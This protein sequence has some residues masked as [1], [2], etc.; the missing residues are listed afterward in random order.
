[1]AGQTD[2][3]VTQLRYFVKAAKLGSMSKA[4]RSLFV[5]EQALSKGVHC[6]EEALGAELLARS[7]T[8]V[9]TTEFGAFFLKRAELVLASLDLA[10]RSAQDFSAESHRSISLGMPNRC[11]ADYG[12]S[13]SVRRLHEL[14]TRF[15]NVTFNFV[16][17]TMENIRKRLCDSTLQFG[18]GPAKMGAG[19]QL[20]ELARF[21]LVVVADSRSPLASRRQVGMQD[22]VGQRIALT[23]GDEGVAA[24]VRELSRE[25]AVSIPTVEASIAPVDPSELIVSDDIVVI[26]PEQHARRCVGDQASLI[27][28]VDAGA[29]R[30]CVPLNLWWKKSMP[31]RE[32]ERGLVEYLRE[33]YANRAG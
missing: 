23:R 7:H 9:R 6:L 1:V 3:D 29:R 17:D 19:F 16:E 27:P 25:A 12:G 13:L 2:L 21:P 8:G 18:I 10:A 5:S 4:A 20:V 15:A 14:Q 30:V 24:L 11:R 26:E 28:L 32:A 33:L 22:L 31:L